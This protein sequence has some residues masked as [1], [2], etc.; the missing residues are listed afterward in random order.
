M[1]RQQTE[2]DLVDSGNQGPA[3]GKGKKKALAIETKPSPIGRRIVP[4]IEALRSKVEA[5]K[6]RNAN[7]DKQVTVSLPAVILVITVLAQ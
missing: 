5:A 6:R 1:E 4:S 2:D 7:K 3:K